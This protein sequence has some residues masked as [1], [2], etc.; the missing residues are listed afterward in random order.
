MGT[1]S[2]TGR[3]GM[4]E[5]FERRRRSRWGAGFRR[6]GSWWRGRRWIRVAP[7]PVL[8]SSAHVGA[9]TCQSSLGDPGTNGDGTR[10]RTPSPAAREREGRR[11]SV[12]RNTGRG[13]P[14]DGASG[15]HSAAHPAA[16]L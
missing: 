4:A 16:I 2:G 1:G 11:D 5:T 13:D 15:L 8:L 9:L 7:N 14:A 10:A 6:I 3:R 12:G